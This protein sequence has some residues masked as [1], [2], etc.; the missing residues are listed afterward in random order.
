MPPVL[1]P[2]LTRYA[3]NSGIAVGPILFV[4]AVLAVIGTVIAASEGWLT[5]GTSPESAR[6]EASKIIDFGNRVHDSV[7][8]MA[9]L[10]QVPDYGW[11][12]QHAGNGWATQCTDGTCSIFCDSSAALSQGSLY[13]V[14][15]LI[16]PAADFIPH[17]AYVQEDGSIFL[18]LMK[19]VGTSGKGQIAL[20]IQG[21]SQAI[22]QQI[23]YQLGFGSIAPI[24][25]GFAISQYQMTSQ[26]ITEPT[27]TSVGT[28]VTQFAN[29][30]AFCVGNG[31][32]A[33]TEFDFVQILV[34]R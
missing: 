8:L 27:G 5:N 32:F 20:R 9:S 13:C 24:E 3:C 19:S 30:L 29:A 4:V 16:L 21:V 14:P 17:Y 10:Y 28:T 31:N 7:T 26:T 1:P 33:S 6:V 23:N 2:P 11:N 15:D 25:S 22:C 34:V 18:I 12:P